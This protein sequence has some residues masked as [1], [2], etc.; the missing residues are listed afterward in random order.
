MVFNEVQDAA[1]LREK[2]PNLNRRIINKLTSERKN[3]TIVS[4]SISEKT[5]LVKFTVKGTHGS[6]DVDLLPTFYFGGI[7][8][9]ILMKII[10]L[11]EFPN[12]AFRPEVIVRGKYASMHGFENISVII[13]A[14]KF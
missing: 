11:Y 13:S 7:A 9:K 8:G 1:D 6:I 5:F 10:F 14:I 12:F 4:G 3:F 2:L